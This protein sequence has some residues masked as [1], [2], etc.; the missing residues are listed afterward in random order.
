M[1]RTHRMWLLPLKTWA[2]GTWESTRSGGRSTRD[3][4]KAISQPVHPTWKVR[5]CC[6]ECLQKQLLYHRS[7]NNGNNSPRGRQNGN[8]QES[9]A[10]FPQLPMRGFLGGG[11]EGVR[12]SCS[13]GRCLLS[14]AC[15]LD[16]FFSSL[17]FSFL[18]VSCLVSSFFPW[19]FLLSARL[20]FLVCRTSL[21]VF[22]QL[23]CLTI[24][25]G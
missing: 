12:L 7:H 2:N 15:D 16:M 8:G 25:A 1:S 18:V 4:A 23:S 9:I 24:P 3:C 17:F 19:S 13:I 11:K 14:L 22:F 5:G 6:S 10:L 21:C 20:I